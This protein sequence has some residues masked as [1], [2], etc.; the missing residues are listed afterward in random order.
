M[1]PNANSACKARAK[2]QMGFLL[3]R[4]SQMHNRLSFC[5][6][7]D[8]KAEHSGEHRI[9]HKGAKGSFVLS[10]LGFLSPPPLLPPSLSQV[11]TVNITAKV[12]WKIKPFSLGISHHF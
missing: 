4:F 3:K 12:R 5:N 7:S 1:K 6:T 2:R 10:G 9:S 8:A 11:V